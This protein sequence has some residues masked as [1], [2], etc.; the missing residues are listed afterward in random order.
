MAE[1]FGETAVKTVFGIGMIGVTS[2]IGGLAG[3]LCTIGGSYIGYRYG[4]IFK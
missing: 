1:D 2:R 4:N 3:P